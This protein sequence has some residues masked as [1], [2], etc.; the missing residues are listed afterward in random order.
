MNKE[1]NVNFDLTGKT[2]W[3]IGSGDDT[4]PYDDIC[5]AFG[6]AMV[7]PGDYGDAR[8][9]QSAKDCKDAGDNDWGSAL[10]QVKKGHL[11]VLRRGQRRLLA[12]GKVI[13]VYDF[14]DL[15][16]DVHGWPLQHYVGVK[17]FIPKKPITF[18][19]TPLSRSTLA[20]LHSQ[21][22]KD[23]ITAEGFDEYSGVSKNLL[24]LTMPKAV[25]IAEISSALVDHGIR[26]HD[27]ENVSTTIDKIKKLVSW[28]L[29]NDPEA[30][31][32]EI[33]T[34]L[35]IPLMISL[36]WSEQKIKIEYNNI[37]IAVFEKPFKGDYK[38]SPGIIIETKRFSDGLYYAT[39]AAKQYAS[40]YP[41]CFLLIATNGYIYKLYEKS[42]DGF[43][44]K[45]YLNLMDMRERSLLDENI[46]GAAQC[47]I[48][49]SQF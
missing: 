20:G 26:I 40:K 13:Q 2:I 9:P 34:F 45:G 21:K 5:L 27:A 33:R 22:V 38:M 44:E 15:L 17:W 4:R 30:L 29:E 32:H 3:Q 11:I 1:I 6:I 35:V 49:M 16:A 18:T 41:E 7:G 19:D 37:D 36:G 24:D 39:E 31:E 42:A 43:T 46:Y 48:K 25:S 14:S 23:R 10:L 28:Y 8:N 12:V 47:L